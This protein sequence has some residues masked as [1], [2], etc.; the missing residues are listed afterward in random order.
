MDV[1]LSI[2]AIWHGCNQQWRQDIDMEIHT[3]IHDGTELEGT[4]L[5]TSKA[6]LHIIKHFY[7]YNFYN[8][9]YL[10]SILSHRTCYQKFISLA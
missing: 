1:D 9:I 10:N 3:N 7:K 4:I 5:T 6:S 8:A 2:D